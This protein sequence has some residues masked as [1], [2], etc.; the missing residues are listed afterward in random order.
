[1]FRATVLNIA[2]LIPAYCT[3]FLLINYCSDMLRRQFLAIFRELI[4]LCSWPRTSAAT[5]RS[6]N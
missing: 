2:Y 6:N 4:S 3:V 1:M 5:C